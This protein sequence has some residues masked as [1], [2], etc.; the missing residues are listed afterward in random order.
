MTVKVRKITKYSKYFLLL[1]VAS[2]V[3]W[4]LPEKSGS[5]LLSDVSRGGVIPVAHA[6]V[7]PGSN[8]GD[9]GGD[10]CD[11]GGDCDT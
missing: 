10:G 6:D 9:D 5:S 11:D 1:A 7:G 8:P 3:S 2:L 4:V